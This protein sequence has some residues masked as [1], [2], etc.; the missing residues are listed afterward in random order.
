MTSSI[1]S[2]AAFGGFALSAGATVLSV[3]V[4]TAVQH[5]VNSS[6]LGVLA[7]MVTEAVAFYFIGKKLFM[8]SPIPPPPPLATER[9][10]DTLAERAR[11]ARDELLERLADIE[12]GVAG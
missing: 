6:G 5:A 8:N 3:I 7:G 1:S 11:D 9:E 2:A 10:R 4:G 12:D